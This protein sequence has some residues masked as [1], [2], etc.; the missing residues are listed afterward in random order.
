MYHASILVICYNLITASSMYHFF[1][2]N[3]DQVED[4]IHVWMH[5]NN[6]LIKDQVVKLFYL[7]Q[8]HTSPHPLEQAYLLQSTISNIDTIFK[9]TDCCFKLQL[10]TFE[11]TKRYLSKN[12]YLLATNT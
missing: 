3:Y 7:Y 4:S 5:N 9:L 10:L 8:D 6:E 1:V 11:E 2:T 12:K